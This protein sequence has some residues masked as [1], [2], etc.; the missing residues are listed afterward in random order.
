MTTSQ[1]LIKQVIDEL[2]RVQSQNSK[3]LE[4]TYPKVYIL[5][6]A[7]QEAVADTLRLEKTIHLMTKN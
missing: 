4:A 1:T 7:Y 3:P 2:T 6:K 5:M